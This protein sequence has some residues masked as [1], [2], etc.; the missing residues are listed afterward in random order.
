[1]VARGISPPFRVTLNETIHPALFSRTRNGA[2]FVSVPDWAVRVTTEF[3][4][5]YLPLTL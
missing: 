4:L 3:Q 5:S 1:M 2:L